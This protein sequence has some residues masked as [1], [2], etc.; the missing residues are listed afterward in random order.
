MVKEYVKNGGNKKYLID[1]IW[2]VEKN[3]SKLC[4]SCTV[5]VV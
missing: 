2:K 4:R 3:I 5:N 1:H